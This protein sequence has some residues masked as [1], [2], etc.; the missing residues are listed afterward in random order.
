MVLA[1]ETQGK[2][3]DWRVWFAERSEAA[4]C[5]PFT[6]WDPRT[7]C[8]ILLWGL[9]SYSGFSQHAGHKP[10]HVRAHLAEEP[11]ELCKPIFKL[12][13]VTRSQMRSHEAK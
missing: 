1:L 9:D 2:D 12:P 10:N 3:G 6:F 13:D 7:D 4:I 11:L 8:E 5:F